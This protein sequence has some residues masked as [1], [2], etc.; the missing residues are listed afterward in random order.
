MF[1][2][3]N[4]D[5]F[6]D[7]E[8]FAVERRRQAEAMLTDMVLDLELE[9]HLKKASPIDREVIIHILYRGMRNSGRLRSQTQ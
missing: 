7:P 8:E 6:D 5:D 1:K 4:K 9:A 2:D 3:L